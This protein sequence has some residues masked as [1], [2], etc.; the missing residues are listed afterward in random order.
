MN[1]PDDVLMAYADGELD[2]KTRAQVEEAIA[3]DPQIARRVAEH[4]AL[5]NRLR[6]SYDPVLDERIPDVLL[7]AAR[8]TGSSQ[9]R[10]VVVPLRPKQVQ[11]RSLP[12]WGAIAASFVVG[13]LVW[14]FGGQLYSS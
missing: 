13:V 5:R 7:A 12:H 6:S 2:T 8:Q 11:A 3:E 10:G 9:L 1:I 4:T 14:H